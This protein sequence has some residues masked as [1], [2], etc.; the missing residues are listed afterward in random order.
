MTRLVL[1]VTVLVLLASVVTIFFVM[2]RQQRRYAETVQGNFVW[3]AVQ[4]EKEAMRFDKALYKELAALD[5]NGTAA[6]S[7]VADR[8]DILF[9]R[10]HDVRNGSHGPLI[11]RDPRVYPMVAKINV[12]VLAMAEA[13]DRLD[14]APDRRA[15]LRELQRMLEQLLPVAGELLLFVHRED[16]ES[17]YQQ[18]DQTT[19]F[20]RLFAVATAGL[21][22]ALLSVM[23]MLLRHMRDTAR[24]KE[25]IDAVERESLAKSLEIARRV[26]E[27][28]HMQRE[29]AFSER[30]NVFNSRV[31]QSVTSLAAMIEDIT[32]QCMAM[33][34]AAERARVGSRESASSSARVAEHVSRV[35][36][37]ADSMLEA[38]RDILRKTIETDRTAHGVHDDADSTGE[39]IQKLVAAAAQIDS[40]VQLIAEVAG[41]TNLLALN[42]TIEAARAGESGRGFAV[43]AGEVKSLASQ[44]ANATSEIGRQ[45]DSI[46]TATSSCVTAM[47]NIRRRIVSLGT[48]GAQITRITENQ[49]VMAE[50]VATMINDA[51]SE[52]TRASTTAG[53]VMEAA[54][55]AN[56][57]AEAV[58]GLMVRVN[59][60][61]RRIRRE[62]ELFRASVD[63]PFG[64]STAA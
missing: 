46:K 29:A 62:I 25:K 59:D 30:V 61:G 26:D 1:A 40:V 18:R 42:A 43:V 31:N 15:A 56:E 22:L 23:G 60:E 50:G 5:G 4:I 20:Q 48:I 21:T 63:E 35:A 54:E 37:S 39:T 24:T 10:I 33:A 3:S 19:F 57:A 36:R 13:V 17:V 8:F 6:A 27:A 45:I 64:S 53:A 12:S 16:V 55:C 9:S 49:S 2:E 38:V 41:R 51:A 7:E 11:A 34:K 44:T 52:T 28:A 14:Q 47:D 58:L 32:G